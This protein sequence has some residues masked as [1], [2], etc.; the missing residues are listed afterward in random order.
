M[1]SNLQNIIELAHNGNRHKARQLL[2]RYVRKN[3]KDAFAWYELS[4]LVE[5]QE[6]KIDCLQYVLKLR[7]N[8]APAKRQLQL[9]ST[10]TSA[11]LHGYSEEAQPN[12]KVS[13]QIEQAANK[14]PSLPR[15]KPS[16][17]QTVEQKPGQSELPDILQFLFNDI[18]QLPIIS[19]L[20]QELWLGIQLQVPKRLNAILTKWQPTKD[21]VTFSQVLWESLLKNLALL[22]KE[23]LAQ[24]LPLPR[25]TVWITEL[26]TARSNICELRRSRLHRFIRLI[27]SLANE[28]V[29]RKLLALTYAVVETMAVLT[30]KELRTFGDFVSLHN[31][32][33]A[34]DEVKEW[35]FV[36]QEVI[37]Q[38]VKKRAKQ[39]VH[40]LTTGYLRYALRVARGHVG[41]G[42][43]YAD[44]AQASFMGLLRAA[45]KFDY[46]V[47]ARFGTYATSWIWQAIGREIADQGRTIRLPVHVQENQ[48]KWKA[49]CDQY[50]NG[51]CDPIYNPDILFQAGFLT[52][53]DHEQ[54]KET[55]S[56]AMPLPAAVERRFEQAIAKARRLNSHPTQI[57]GLT[58]V[59]AFL[60]LT[61]TPDAA[62]C[63]DDLIPNEYSSPGIEVDRLFVRQIIENEVFPFLTDRECEVLKL[64]C[65]WTDG[66]E[67]TLEEIGAS[68]GLTR[69]RIRQIEAKA[70]KTL[71]NR[72]TL[73]L[74][75]NP[76][77]LLPEI[78]PVINWAKSL[79]IAALPVK[80]TEEAVGQKWNHVDSLLNQ[81]PRGNWVEG[82][83]GLR[84]GER[85]DQ[86]VAALQLLAAP[87]HVTDI[88][89]QLNE[90]VE[91]PQID[92][93]NV[94][95]LLLR[96][97][98]KFIL[99]GQGIFSLV[100]W[101]KARA[102]EQFVILPCCPMPLPD[103]PDYEDAFFESVLVGQQALVRELA[104]EQ[105]I[106]YMLNWAKAEPDQQKWFVQNVLSAYY[107]VDLIPY[108]FYFGGANPVLTCTL[109]SG[110][111]QELR[112]HCL[113]T[114]TERLATMPEFWWL[115]QQ[116]QPA[117][118]T[119]LGERFADIHPYG[120]D[121]V[122]QRLRLLASLGA[123][124]KSRYGEYRLT[125]LG[126]ECA[127]QWKKEPM[128]ETV[129]DSETNLIYDFAGLATW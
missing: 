58:E 73:G 121:D 123:T 47:Q 125:P 114:L 110:T 14:K 93:T 76:Y 68:Y 15:H 30:G 64:R 6:Q 3:P 13:L 60:S 75:P 90:L 105:F 104:A 38:Q 16:L 128:V 97:E 4:F 91:G 19:S 26:L 108:V 43:D 2:M 24:E 54:I 122:L 65:G 124:Q 106:R 12:E 17:W 46:R 113:A 25:F 63:L 71:N 49:A 101:E 22:E 116:N 44:L 8:H 83:S 59:D 18:A 20:H 111:I 23:C 109:P 89:E 42:L 94:Y 88:A 127:N 9:I 74:L 79:Q 40:L 61:S 80:S 118:P 86:L 10:P 5:S 107:L 87:A 56:L 102:T 37:E 72:I 51:H 34:L 67:L 53:D 126:E 129:I 39:T 28:D 11:L 45:S 117:R 29:A 57:V 85:R 62:K 36:S 112:Y 48:R 81:L 35:A 7:P 69:E 50:D 99:L 33:P 78:M 21:E 119:D 120:L 55:N 52:R 98:E 31:R 82:R 115:L 96:D 92:D 84:G 100:E 70:I 1:N 27:N 77:D 95:N 32:Q 66:Q 103:P 41:Q